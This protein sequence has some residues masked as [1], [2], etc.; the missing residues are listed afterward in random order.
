MMA[1]DGRMAE[2][3]MRLFAIASTAIGIEGD[4]LDRLIDDV[5]KT[6]PGD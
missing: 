5:V 2:P 6:N 4:E 3:E 1:A